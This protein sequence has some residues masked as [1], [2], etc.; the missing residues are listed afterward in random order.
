[1]FRIEAS[2]QTDSYCDG[3]SRRSFLQV[4]V[5]G[6]ASLPLADVLR[7]KAASEDL[8]HAKK[9]TAVIL[10]WLD[11]GAS[12]MDLWDMKPDAPV[13][14]RGLWWPIRTNVRGVE[15]SEMLPQQA[16]V[17]DKFSIV[18]SLCNNMTHHEPASR[19]MLTGRT[20]ALRDGRQA[21]YPSIGSIATK[22][23]GARRQGIPP[24][25]SVPV[26]STIGHVPG[27]LGASYLGGQHNPFQTGGD[28]NRADFEVKNLSPPPG[29]SIQRLEDRDGLRKKFDQWHR[30]M[31]A[32]DAF[33]AMNRFDQQAFELVAGPTARKAFDI[34]LED[35]SLRDRYGRNTWGQSALLA[36]RLVEAGSTFVTVHFG[37][38]DHHWNLEAGMNSHLPRLDT[39]V[40][41]LFEDLDARGLLDQVLV[42]VGGEFGRTPRVNNGHG[43]GA[44]GRDHWGPAFSCLM[45]GGGVHG[46]QILGAT[47]KRGE[48]V[49][50]RPVSPGDFQATIY[51]VLGVDSAINLLD[52]VGRPVPAVVDGQVIQELLT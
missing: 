10:V 40:S 41:A 51:H 31:E 1:M 34:S 6:M 5:A 43:K 18:R 46:G 16:K 11:G 2:G 13:E 15:I 25:I 8:G 49:T 14:Y 39:A 45:G 42:V 35:E 44:P 4:G 19:Y 36:R 52:L 26:A 28:P 20:D 50:D 29:M 30:D 33:E 7:A 27:Y 32:S 38:W 3:M 37:G 21:K 47:D 12:H 9:D 48:Y 17:A 24:Y 22:V 23:C